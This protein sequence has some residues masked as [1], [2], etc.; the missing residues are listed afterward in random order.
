MTVS[1]GN[2]PK[3]LRNLGSL[4]I[5]GPHDEGNDDLRELGHFRVIVDHIWTVSLQSKERLRGLLLFEI[6]NIVL[7]KGG[8]GEPDLKLGL[9]HQKVSVFI[10]DWIIIKQC[11]I[12]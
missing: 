3:N 10:S 8:K 4:S 6:L 9:G 7:V 2:V 5:P 12:V 11:D 1:G